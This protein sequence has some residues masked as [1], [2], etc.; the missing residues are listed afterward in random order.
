MSNIAAVLPC[1]CSGGDPCGQ[2]CCEQGTTEFGIFWSGSFQINFNPCD[3]VPDVPNFICPCFGQ[4][5]TQG[6]QVGR[7]RI[8]RT[9]PSPLSPCGECSLE[10]EAV[11]RRGSG[12]Y[13]C[14]CA[15][16][17]EDPP[18]S[19]QF[20]TCNDHFPQACGGFEAISGCG[21]LEFDFQSCTT[22]FVPSI[23]F[24]ADPTPNGRW[25]VVVPIRFLGTARG[26][27]SAAMNY[28]HNDVGSGMGG[29]SGVLSPGFDGAA[30]LGPPVLRCADGRIDLRSRVGTYSPYNIQTYQAANEVLIWTPGTVQV[31]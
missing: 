29:V 4:T 14:P 12:A 27:E 11:E 30:Y 5:I 21:W 28:C 16:Q 15:C 9:P 19:G 18:G 7:G 1:C 13:F 23:L 25:H 20:Y 8:V 22:R 17:W 24:G 31:T 10:L 6:G 2:P 3:C 26:C